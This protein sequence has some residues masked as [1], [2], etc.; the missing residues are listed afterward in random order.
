MKMRDWEKFATF[1][2]RFEAE[3]YETGW[4]YPALLW[5]LRRALPDRITDILRIAP[6]PPDY[7]GFKDLV[8]QIDRKYW[9][10]KMAEEGDS[11][12]SK[13]NNPTQK[14]DQRKPV[15]GAGPST[16]RNA[17]LNTADTEEEQD[18]QE[19]TLNAVET[20]EGGRPWIRI[21]P[22]EKERRRKE[23]S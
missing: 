2:V 18:T 16:N 14:A 4:N 5:A 12:R 23:G 9:E 11:W 20:Q 21:P 7:E 8:A 3:A 19:S 17:K 13:W 6:N 10:D 22:E 1:S 15:P